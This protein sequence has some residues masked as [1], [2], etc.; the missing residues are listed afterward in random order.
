MQGY[1]ETRRHS[2]ASVHHTKSI[3]PVTPPNV[4]EKYRKNRNDSPLT[5]KLYRDKIALFIK[6]ADV[7]EL[8]D[9]VDLGSSVF[10]V[11]VRVLSSAPKKSDRLVLLQGDCSFLIY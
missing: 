8:V 3:L 6:S 2:A 4:K 9:S 5:T 1:H 11:Q 10:D 7:V